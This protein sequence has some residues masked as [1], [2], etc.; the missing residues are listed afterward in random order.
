MNALHSSPK[1]ASLSLRLTSAVLALAFVPTASA[2]LVAW[3]DFNTAPAGGV[4]P[5][6]RAGL[7]PRVLGGA[8]QTPDAEGRT[9]AAGDRAMRFGV[10]QQRLHLTDASYFTAAA[11]TNTLSVSYWIRQ[12]AI[13]NSTALSFVAPS[14]GGRG[15]QAHSPWSDGTIYF[16]TGGCCTGGIHRTFINPGLTWTQWRHVALVKEA[17]NKTIYVDG[18]AVTAGFDTAPINLDFTELFIGNAP[19]AAEAVNGDIDDFAVYSHALTPTDVTALAGGAPPTAVT[20]VLANDTD[21]DT[22]P[23]L[24][25]RRFYPSDLTQLAGGTAD[26]DG[27]GLTNVTELAIGTNPAAADTDGDGLADG[28]ETGTGTWVSATNTGTSP[29]I[30]DTDG[31]GLNDAAETNTGTFLSATNAG[32]NPHVPD[33]DGDLIPDGAEVLYGSSPVNPASTPV[34]PGVPTLLAW[35]QFDND[36]NPSVALDNRVGHAGTITTG[37]Q[38]SADAEGFTGQAGDKAL[39]LTA[40]G[41]RMR[42]DNASWTN[43]A[44]RIDKL[45][46]TFWQKLVT[47]PGSSSFW[48]VSP[49][50]AGQRG[51]QAHVP[52][53]NSNIFFDHSGCCAA[54]QRLNGAPGID[55]TQ[56]HHFV[57]LKDG[58]NKRIYIDGVEFLA[59]AGAAPLPTDFTVLHVGSDNGNAR[60]DGS[61]DDFAI[62]AAALNTTDIQALAARTKTPGQIGTSSDADADGLPDAWEFLY[63]PGDL[64][65]LG[66]APADFDADSSPDAQE[67]TR[68]TNPTDSD[69]DDDGLLDGVESN[70]GT[71]VSATNTGTNPNRADTDGDGLPDGAENNSGSYVSQANPGTNPNLADSDGDTF[72]DAAEGIY[73]ANPNVAGS[74]PFTPGS[75]FLLAHWN[76]NDAS[77]PALSADAVIGIPGTV[78]GLFSDAGG[79]RTG[80]TE[81]RAMCFNGTQSVSAPAAFMNVGSP[82]DKMTIAFWQKLNQVTAST[83]FWGNSPSSF[84]SRGI[85]AHTPWNNNNLYFDHSGCCGAGTQRIEGP[86]PATADL[87]AWTHF[88]FVKDGAT[89][90][91][92]VNGQPAITGAGTDRLPVDFD[93]LSIGSGPPGGLDGCIDDFAVYAGALD[94]T[95]VTRLAAGET[96]AAVLLPPVA[97]NF[98]ITQVRLNQNG[99]VTLTWNSEIGVNYTIQGSPTMAE[100]TWTNLG[101]PIT[102]AAATTSADATAPVAGINYFFRVRR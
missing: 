72:L 51:M 18:A 87:F 48:F 13:R 99:S 96:P 64:T 97:G 25:E 61:I 24:W 83:A 12:N 67:L 26:R 6:Q 102:A 7:A 54:N 53:S 47:T 2:D 45:T 34:Q 16:D 88:A 22:L 38:Y 94:T 68:N 55:F 79:G 31:D 62:F 80:A 36:S 70:T 84:G 42:I 52:W 86:V 75:T 85:Q 20:N 69:S 101:P 14:V 77:N 30:A 56:W 15:F 23:D 37:A 35:W 41:G 11:A 59:G 49:S 81:D 100:G 17:E 27:D 43:M 29:L 57:F 21:G 1:V 65:K 32:T 33:T 46:V 60:I 76:F 28:V 71:W 91:V 44:T 98:A 93:T 19:N 39:V 82:G 5:D 40:A 10:A 89:K 73:G 90:T 50:A 78:T 58:A 74:V 66:A 3:W 9:G 63:F 8:A 92:Y 4:V 95:Q